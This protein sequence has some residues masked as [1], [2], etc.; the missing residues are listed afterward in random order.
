MKN[1]TKTELKTIAQGALKAKY[2]FTPAKKQ[3]ILLESG[4]ND[5]RIYILFSVNNHVYNFN[6]TLKYDSK[7]GFCLGVWID[8]N[9][10]E[11]ES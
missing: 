3:I 9:A 4:G 2:G 11:Q 7:D 8:K 10:I 1:L 5:T 6:S